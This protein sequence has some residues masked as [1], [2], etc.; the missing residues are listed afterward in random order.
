[1]EKDLIDLTRLVLIWWS[2]HQDDEGMDQ[3]PDFVI[4]ALRI[5]KLNTPH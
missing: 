5:H 1:M 3:P 4:L 2:E